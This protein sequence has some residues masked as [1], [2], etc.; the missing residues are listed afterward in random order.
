MVSMA[1]VFASGTHDRPIDLGRG[2]YRFH[3]APNGRMTR[4]GTIEEQ[5]NM[6]TE[7]LAT[8]A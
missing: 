8:R 3:P 6:V 4:A 1:K 5:F 2:V 7:C